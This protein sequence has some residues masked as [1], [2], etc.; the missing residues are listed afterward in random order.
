VLEDIIVASISS[1]QR[2]RAIKM[3]V[4]AASAAIQIVRVVP[5]SFFGKAGSGGACDRVG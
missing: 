5:G 1:A 3:R 4:A 2:L